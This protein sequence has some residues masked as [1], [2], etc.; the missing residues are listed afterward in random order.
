VG[1][2]RRPY[3]N[4]GCNSHEA[5]CARCDEGKNLRPARGTLWC[6]RAH[7]Q[8]HY[9]HTGAYLSIAV[10]L[11]NFDDGDAN[12]FDLHLGDFN[13]IELSHGDANEYDVARSGAASKRDS[14][15]FI[16]PVTPQVVRGDR[17]K[18]CR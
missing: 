14:G 12:T 16:A 10:A 11:G 6:G 7:C 1:T 15:W 9:T 8:N 3:G 13:S 4:R 2:R 5:E 18:T 17:R